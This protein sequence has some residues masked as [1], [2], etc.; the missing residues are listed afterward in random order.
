MSA[1]TWDMFSPVVNAERKQAEPLVKASFAPHQIRV[2]E[3]AYD[4]A[5]FP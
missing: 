3:R 5:R 2:L 4:S 1:F